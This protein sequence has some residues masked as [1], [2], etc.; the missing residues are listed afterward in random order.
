MVQGLI[1]GAGGAA[2]FD[3]P[4]ADFS[5]GFLSDVGEVVGFM[6]DAFVLF[7]RFLAF[8]LVEALPVFLQ[9]PLATVCLGSFLVVF[10][11]LMG[12]V[13][14]AIGN[15]IGGFIPF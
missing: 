13:V 4:S 10:V 1:I 7:F 2:D 15:L 14:S 6:A 8:D 5:G 3:S 12:H 11:W 9:V